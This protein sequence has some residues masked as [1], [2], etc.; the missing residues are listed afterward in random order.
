VQDFSSFWLNYLEYYQR[1]WQDM[2]RLWA[3]NLPTTDAKGGSK[4]SDPLNAFSPDAWSALFA[5]WIPRDAANNPFADLSKVAQSSLN[6]FTSW[7]NAFPG[8]GAVSQQ[9]PDTKTKEDKNLSSA[10]RAVRD[11]I[12]RSKTQDA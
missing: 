1:A 9:T 4:P 2:A 6:A 3:P 12:Q 7:G 8:F 5:P 11:A 10:E